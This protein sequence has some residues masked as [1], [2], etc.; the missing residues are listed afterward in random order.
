[1]SPTYWPTNM[2]H[3]YTPIIKIY[4]L[5]IGIYVYID[6]DIVLLLQSNGA[7]V[8]VQTQS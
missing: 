8:G 6:A 3:I 7:S 2:C 1:M 5:V 4:T